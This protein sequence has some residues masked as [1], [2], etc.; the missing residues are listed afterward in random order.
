MKEHNLMSSFELN[1]IMGAIFSIVLVLLVIKNL[2][3]I[4]Y[5]EDNTLHQ[6]E[7]KETNIITEVQI[8]PESGNII[9]FSNII[10]LLITTSYNNISY[11]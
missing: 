4:L 1:K 5:I 9:R 2:S 8:K 6:T 3:N 11:I 7:I 10:Y